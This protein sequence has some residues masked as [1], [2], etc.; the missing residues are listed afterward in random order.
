MGKVE[1]VGILAFVEARVQVGGQAKDGLPES[2]S[3]HSHH[4]GEAETPGGSA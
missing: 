3:N 4:L 1:C 2:I